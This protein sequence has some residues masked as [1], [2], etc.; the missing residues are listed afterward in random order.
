MVMTSS[1]RSPL[2]EE[3]ILVQIYLRDV[4]WLLA[5]ITCS[6]GA[7]QVEQQ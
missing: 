1:T 7:S 2:R 4:F 3:G 6:M 5:K